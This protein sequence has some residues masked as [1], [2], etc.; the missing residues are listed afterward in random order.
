MRVLII[1]DHPDIAANVGD[2]LASR[3]HVTD[4]AA[5]GITGL[6]LAV[7]E[8]FDAIV[9]DL[10][11]PG[12]DGLTLAKRLREDAR[13]NTPILMLTARDTLQDRLDGFKA[14]GDDYLIKPFSL[15]ELEARLESLHRRSQG[16]GDAVLTLETLSFDPNTL[17][18][19]R[20]ERRIELKPMARK[21]LEVLLR[22]RGR[23][24]SRAELE[25]ALW[26]EEPPEGDALR[27][28]IHALRQALDAPG[29][30]PLLQTIR[31]AG[32]RLALKE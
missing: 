12:M 17:E 24:L 26:G 27:V 8:D 14:G 29:E 2:F 31:G 7:T 32:Y 16:D 1:E 22:A 10:M 30:R 13:R 25:T 5:D 18:I 3:G 28:H 15:L 4:F 11:L 21:L 19:R 23:V 9:L 20:G 6:H